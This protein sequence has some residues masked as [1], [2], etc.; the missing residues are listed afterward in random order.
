M[1]GERGR[2]ERDRNE[3]KMQR[4]RETDGETKNG[5]WQGNVPGNE[6]SYT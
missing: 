2:G 1:K 5:K 4:E 3:G 6:D